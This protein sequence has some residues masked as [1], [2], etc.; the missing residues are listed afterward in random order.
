MDEHAVAVHFG[1]MIV[2]IA[3]ETETLTR[4]SDCHTET[5]VVESAR[6]TGGTGTV[7]DRTASEDAIVFEV[8]DRL[9][10]RWGGCAR[11]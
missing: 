8:A 9:H 2:E 3:E 7:M 5:T 1:G 4:E 11:P 10:R 6:G